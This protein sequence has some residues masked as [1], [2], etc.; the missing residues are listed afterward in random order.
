MDITPQWKTQITW[1]IL[2]KDNTIR[3]PL[4]HYKQLFFL[5]KQCG[6]LYT[7]YIFLI[8]W[9]ITME[10]LIIKKSFNT[11]STKRT[12]IFCA[13]KRVN[14]PWC[15]LACLFS[16]RLYPYMKEIQIPQLSFVGLR[17]CS[18]VYTWFFMF[19]VELR[20]VIVC[21]LEDGDRFMFLECFFLWI[22]LGQRKLTFI[23]ENHNKKMNWLNMK[24]IGCSI[25]LK[26]SKFGLC[27][28]W[29]LM[30]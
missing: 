23:I 1:F 12:I 9:S 8:I 17:V 4:K 3:V 10:L 30:G 14:E 18:E 29:H 28:G 7:I 22:S 5:S 24:K 21:I 20:K 16:I 13:I 27:E 25:I 26:S 2:Q 15:W 11:L 6:I 19:C